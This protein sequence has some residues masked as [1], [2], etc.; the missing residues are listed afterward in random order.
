MNMADE[1][2]IEEAIEEECD[3]EEPDYWA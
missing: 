3:W 1:E 2:M